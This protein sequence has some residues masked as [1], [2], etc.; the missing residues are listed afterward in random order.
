VVALL[1]EVS[2]GLLDARKS[3][4]APASTFEP[5][6]DSQLGQPHALGTTRKTAIGIAGAGVAALISAAAFESIARRK[7]NDALSLCPDLNSPCLRAN[8]A[9]VFVRS[10]N[11]WAF[12][13]N[14]A[15]GLGGIAANGAVRCGSRV[16]GRRRATHT[17][18]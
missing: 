1:Y 8:E 9:N 7:H 18:L 6:P 15:W 11:S 3:R 12:K 4:A 2:A 13:S 5:T 10:G 16:H 14:V 17:P